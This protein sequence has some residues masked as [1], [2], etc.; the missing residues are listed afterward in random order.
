MRCSRVREML[1]RYLAEECS[2]LERTALTRH[3][4]G[5]PG[6]AVRAAELRRLNELLDL[7][8]PEPAP[9]DLL[10]ALLLKVGQLSSEG[11]ARHRSQPVQAVPVRTP[12]LLRHLAVAVALSLAFSWGI[13]PW[14]AGPYQM[15][16]T[17]ETDRLVHSYTT[18]TDSVMKDTVN[19]IESQTAKLNFEEWMNR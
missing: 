15:L 12:E 7:W 19:V 16:T 11:R 13:G 8:Q 5:C 1:S 4:D 17:T 18:T 3:L 9:D 14:L 6:C 2:T 10:E